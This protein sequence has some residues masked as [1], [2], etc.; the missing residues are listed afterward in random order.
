MQNE[1]LR[2]WLKLVTFKDEPYPGL[3]FV[4]A[5]GILPVTFCAYFFLGI[6]AAPSMNTATKA[7]AVV[8]IMHVV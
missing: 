3:L 4:T 1:K 6:L 8:A 5:L 7:T 2:N